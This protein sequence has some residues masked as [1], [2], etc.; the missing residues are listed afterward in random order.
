MKARSTFNRSAASCANEV[1]VLFDSPKTNASGPTAVDGCEVALLL[2]FP[3]TEPSRTG[4]L[5]LPVD[6]GAGVCTSSVADNHAGRGRI[7]PPG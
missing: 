3:S 5:E 7:G 4:V 2:E 1:K 6:P